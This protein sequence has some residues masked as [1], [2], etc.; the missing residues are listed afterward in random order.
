MFGQEAAAGIDI[1]ATVTGEAAYSDELH[2]APR[3]GSNVAGGLRSILYPTIKLDDHWNLSGAI[4]AI[5]RPFDPQDFSR[6]GDSIRGR[7][8]QATLGYSVVGKKGSV[9]IRAGQMMS[10]FG[11]FLMHYDDAD[12]ALVS[13]PAMYGY[14]YNPVSVL[15]VAG[16]EADATYG[17]WDARLQFANSSPAN[18]RSLFDKDQYA[19]WAGGAGYTIRQG[20]RA[21]FSGYRG[22]YLDRHYPFYFPGEAKP[23]DLP[24]SGVGVDADWATG[25]WNVRGEW[26]KFVMSYKSIPTFHTNGAYLEAER[27]LTPRWFV[28]ARVGYTHSS[29]ASGYQTFEAAAGF[30]PDAAQIVKAGYV[31]SRSQRNGDLDKALVL[32]IVTSVHPLSMAW[33]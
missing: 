28:A 5:T 26:Q 32:Q 31:V 10:A 20:L 4:E 1:R 17:R 16:A 21:G 19:N 9:S 14:Y 15:G 29:A 27:V 22:P 18:P 24:A 6:P 23:H 3:D 8:L 13:A 7:V 2:N 12:N 33:R 25:H 11:S 30:R